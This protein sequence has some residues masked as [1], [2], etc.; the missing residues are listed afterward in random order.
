MDT[1]QD[2][3]C[4]HATVMEGV[5]AALTLD[6]LLQKHPVLLK[7]QKIH[8]QFNSVASF[9]DEVNEPLES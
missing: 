3:S 8:V 5:H 1:E 7:F 6:K 4:A 2:M 9:N